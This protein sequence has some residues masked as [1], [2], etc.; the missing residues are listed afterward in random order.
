MFS[1]SDAWSVPHWPQHSCNRCKLL[2][3]ASH[4]TSK[5]TN[6]SRQPCIPRPLSTWKLRSPDQPIYGGL[7]C[8][9]GPPRSFPPGAEWRT[10]RCYWDARWTCPPCSTSRGSYGANPH[11]L[12]DLRPDQDR[13][14]LHSW[15]KGWH[16]GPHGMSLESST[17]S[18]N[19]HLSVAKLFFIQFRLQD[20]VV[21]WMKTSLIVIGHGAVTCRC[22]VRQVIFSMTLWNFGKLIWWC[23]DDVR[24]PFS[25]V[26]HK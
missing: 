23:V 18:H 24:Q 9:P 8:T 7:I 17:S 25:Q 6:G 26:H 4:P 3:N 5:T 15:W 2:H 12:W 19:D 10:P 22:S 14:C 13:K 1:G 16:D 20:V 21:P 11:E